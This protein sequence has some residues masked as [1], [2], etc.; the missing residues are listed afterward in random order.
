ME[1]EKSLSIN[2]YEVK[3]TIYKNAISSKFDNRRITIIKRDDDFIFEF[4]IIDHNNKPH[5]LCEFVRN[6]LAITTIINSKEA[7]EIIMFNLAELMG[8]HICKK[9]KI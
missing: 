1:K 7:A 4:R 2:K 3:R 8:F 6:K 9:E 5:A